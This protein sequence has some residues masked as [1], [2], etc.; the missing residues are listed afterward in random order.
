MSRNDKMKFIRLIEGS[1]LTIS[2]A[3]AKYDLPGSAWKKFL[4][5]SGFPLGPNHRRRLHSPSWLSS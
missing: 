2:Y 5:P 4:L 1:G 3:L